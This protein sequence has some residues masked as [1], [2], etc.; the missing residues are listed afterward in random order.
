MQSLLIGQL[1]RDGVSTSPC[2]S[3]V[4][5]SL[6]VYAVTKTGCVDLHL[7]SQEQFNKRTSMLFYGQSNGGRL[8]NTGLPKPLPG[9]LRLTRVQHYNG[10]G[11][12]S[13]GSKRQ[14]PLFIPWLSC[15]PA[16]VILEIVLD[17]TKI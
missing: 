7:L 13:Q 6:F 16:T 3:S 17:K 15:F 14:P 2:S 10:E 5:V 8:V 11:A 9:I 4:L 1:K 12:R